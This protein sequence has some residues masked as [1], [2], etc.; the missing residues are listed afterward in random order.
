MARQTAESRPPDGV[1][2]DHQHLLGERRRGRPH[3]AVGIGHQR[4]AVEHHRVLAADAID[5]GDRN[6]IATGRVFQ[7]GIAPR[8]LVALEWRGVDR[9]DQLGTGLH[10]RVQRLGKPHVL[11]DQQPA[12]HAVEFEHAVAAVGVDHEVAALVEH[13][14][15]GELALAVRVFDPAAAQDAGGVV[16]HRP[17][18]LRP[19]HNRGDA[20]RRG[21]D[22]FHCDMAVAQEARAQQQVLWRVAAERELREQHK[23]RAVFVARFDD[24]LDDPVGVVEHGPDRKVELGEGDADGL[25]H[26]GVPSG[27][28]P[29]H[30][31]RTA[32][33]AVKSP[34]RRE[35]PPT[36]KAT[37]RWPSSNARRLTSP[38]AWRSPRRDRPAT[39]PW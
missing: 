31:P 26:G 37:R 9:Q 18:G 3:G 27:S 21:G 2:V 15:V 1:E 10:R 11:T 7:Q 25:A 24:V 14:V 35:A 8:V 13:R 4:A 20:G 29:G 33:D 30:C 22:A 28:G 17:R 39:S 5:V 6:A 34:R 32:F 36:K 19:A 16:H 23:V 38:G 12:A